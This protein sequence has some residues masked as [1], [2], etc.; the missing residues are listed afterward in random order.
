M[1]HFGDFSD[2]SQVLLAFQ[3][4]MVSQKLVNPLLYL[5]INK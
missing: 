3:R 4:T 1:E 5:E 2:G